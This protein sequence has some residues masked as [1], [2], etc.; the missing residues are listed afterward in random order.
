MNLGY[1]HSLHLSTW[2][3][4]VKLAVFANLSNW[5][6][7]EVSLNLSRPNNYP[8]VLSQRCADMSPLSCSEVYLG[9]TTFSHRI[10]TDAITNYCG[11]H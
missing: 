1:H 4:P 5:S 10:V 2:T 7:Y 8:V 3:Y 11:A 9:T 6:N